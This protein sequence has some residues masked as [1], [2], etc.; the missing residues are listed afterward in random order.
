MGNMR[1]RRRK[2]KAARREPAIHKSTKPF[3]K[4]AKPAGNQTGL[5]SR[6]WTRGDSVMWDFINVLYREYCLARL[7]EMRQLGPKN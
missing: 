6:H 7:V 1:A 4:S 2:A 3:S 5:A